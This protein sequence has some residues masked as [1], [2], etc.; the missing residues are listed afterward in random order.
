MTRRK[1][2][3]VGKV[4]KWEVGAMRFSHGVIGFGAVTC[5]FVESILLG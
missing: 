1:V 3:E 4:G 2:I 5:V